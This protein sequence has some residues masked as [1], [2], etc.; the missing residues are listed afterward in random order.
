[1]AAMKLSRRTLLAAAGALPV[2]GQAAG[3]RRLVVPLAVDPIG[4]IPGLNEQP[5]CR[6]VGTKLYQGLVRFSPEPEPLPGLATAWTVSADGLTYT[7]ALR[8]GVTWH[9]GVP[10][11]ADDVVFSLDRFHRLLSPRLSPGLARIAAIRAEG[12]ASVS[13]KLSAPFPPFL[14][15]L[16]A[17]SAPIVP[18]HIHDRPGFGLGFGQDPRLFQPVGTGPFRLA[19][20]LRLIPFDK[21]AGP[22]AG[23]DE[24]VFPILP[25][26]AARIAATQAGQAVLLAADAV[27]L[28]AMPRLRQQ[29]MVVEGQAVPNHA[30]LA[31]LDVNHRAPPLDDERVRLALAYALDRAAILRDVWAGLGRVATAPVPTVS[32]SGV[33]LPAYDPRAAAGQLNEA[34][35]HPDEQGIRLRLS[36]MVRAADPW[37]RLAASLRDAFGQVG[38]MLS[39]ETVEPGDWTRRV[40]AMD[41][42]TTGMMAEFGGDALLDPVARKRLV[43]DVAQ[44]WLVEPSTPVA[45]DR[46]LRVAGGIYTSFA[47]ATL[48]G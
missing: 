48:T 8:P 5:A 6:L 11:D 19:S 4:L 24:I 10:F 42:Q 9:D 38:I 46:R 7:F 29:G 15:L 20:W 32:D 14:S 40:A 30:S 35:L 44:I 43:D 41:Y 13:I 18:R 36:H 1:M 22:A 45:F 25:D 34:G 12:A 23:L 39:L 47:G 16:D 28:A 2:T 26:P 3:S 21:F 37:P 33:P 27:P 31:W 17:A